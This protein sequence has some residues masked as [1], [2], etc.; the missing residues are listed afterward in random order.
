MIVVFAFYQLTLPYFNQLFYPCLKYLP[1]AVYEYK[2]CNLS[3]VLDRFMFMSLTGFAGSILWLFFKK[4]TRK[5]RLIII[6]SI[7][8]TA[9][10]IFGYLEYIKLA[11]KQ[12]Q[13]APIYLD[14]LTKK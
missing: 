1:E 8:L 2:N 9:L 5:W 12:I 10:T 11:E 7:I 6:A 4:N 3:L 14:S 13:N